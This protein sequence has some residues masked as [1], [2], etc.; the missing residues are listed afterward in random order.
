MEWSFYGREQERMG[1]RDGDFDDLYGLAAT[2][3]RLVRE[4]WVVVLD[5][6]T[7]LQYKVDRLRDP[8]AGSVT[9]KLIVLESIQTEMEGPV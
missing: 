3:G 6:Y 4:G 9:C 8:G 2:D 5:Q 7:T 1:V